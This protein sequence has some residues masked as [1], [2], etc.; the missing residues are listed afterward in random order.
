MLT[1]VGEYIVG[2]YLQLVKKCEFI[3]YN[4]RVPG[5][6]MEGLG[7]LDVVGFNFAEN[8]AYL[9]EVTTHIQGLKYGGNTETVERIKKKHERQKQYAE[10]HLRQF[11]NF[12]YMLWSP[13]VPVGYKTEHLKLINSLTLVINGD[14][15]KR[16]GELQ[17]LAADIT[18]DTRNPFFR[19]LQILHCMRDGD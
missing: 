17:R 3:D 13:V 16:I 7:E 12:E 18:Y 4:V 11:N 14:Y 2:A 15:K 9:C 1:D 19:V 6:G 8:K 10:K 5:G